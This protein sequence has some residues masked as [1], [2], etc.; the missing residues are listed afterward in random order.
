MSNISP[1]PLFQLK[2]ESNT[3]WS[4]FISWWSI[5]HTFCLVSAPLFYRGLFLKCTFIFRL[6]SCN[7]MLANHKI[8][9]LTSLIHPVVDASLYSVLCSREYS[10]SGLCLLKMLEA[11][12]DNFEYNER[13]PNMSKKLINKQQRNIASTRKRLTV[14]YHCFFHQS[15]STRG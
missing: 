9:S 3:F 7:L 1:Y 14:D 10:V 5:V 12:A 4:R 6:L 15:V 11:I 8:V 13:F 2:K